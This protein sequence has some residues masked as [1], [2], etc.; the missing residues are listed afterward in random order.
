MPPTA[1]ALS[2]TARLPHLAFTRAPIAV[3]AARPSGAPTQD[4]L[5]RINALARS[6]LAA[7]AVYVFPAEIS[8]QSIDAYYTRMTDASIKQYA[9]DASRGVAI[10]DS[11][12]HYQLPL[13]RSFYG[14]VASSE[15]GGL[16][17]Q[18][19]GYLLR[20]IQTSG[21]VSSDDVIRGIE[22]GI[23][24]DVSI[25][26]IPSA[27]WCSICGLNM[28]ADWDCAHWPGQTYEVHDPKTGSVSEVLCVA[29]VDARLAEYSLVYEGATPNAMVLK[30][31]ATLDSGRALTPELTRQIRLV[32]EHCHVRLLPRH[33]TGFGPGIQARTTGKDGAAAAS[34]EDDAGTDEEAQMRGH[35]IIARFQ[36]EFADAHTRAGKQISA[37]NMERLQA[38]HDQVKA[39]TDSAEEGRRA[40]ADFMTEMS[41]PASD[42]DIPH[43]AAGDDGDGDDD[44]PNGRTLR[45]TPQVAI[46][47]DGSHDPFT[48]THTHAHSAMGSQGGDDTHEHEHTHDGDANHD[49]HANATHSHSQD[50][51]GHTQPH[52]EGIEGRAAARGLTAAPSTPHD[53]LTPEQRAMLSLGERFTRE[54]VDEALAAAVRAGVV[55]TE[56]EKAAKARMLAHCTYDEVREFAESWQTM[57][58]ARLSPRGTFVP[59][60]R[61]LGGGRWTSE[62]TMQGGR[63]TQPADPND[64]Q[65]LTARTGRGGGSS[66]ARAGDSPALYTLNPK[67]GRK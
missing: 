43:T 53:A 46:R 49:H 57:A 37:A 59:D 7:S 48:G 23:Y 39:G 65:R 8:N 42:S 9:A 12:E 36:R 10:C 55:T 29:D 27:Y 22:G 11:H 67:R 13:G 38:I 54:A 28:L 62:P 33:G 35:E 18:S 47:A 17:T 20:G 34:S 56:A 3:T 25:G 63:Q 15:D 6:P 4:D 66:P 1:A 26:F 14:T 58:Q 40:L 61:L 44:T 64:P 50:G 21:G 51:H 60:A 24:S 41:A 19:L 31:E 2:P 45:E 16:V 52:A 32:E 30:A 5:D